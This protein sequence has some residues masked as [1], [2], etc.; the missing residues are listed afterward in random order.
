MAVTV[1]RKLNLVLAP[2]ETKDGLAYIHSVPVGISVFQSCYRGMARAMSSIVTEGMGPITGPSVAAM[3]LQD[4]ADAVGIGDR[5][6]NGLMPE[7]RRLT[8]VGIVGKDSFPY[9]VAIDRK[10][11]DEDKAMEVENLIVYFTLVS[12]IRIPETLSRGMGM[13]GLRDLWGAQITSLELTEFMRS[14]PT[15]MPEGNTGEKPTRPKAAPTS[16]LAA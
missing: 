12:W 1:S 8:N 5:I 3:V 11:I 2:F 14:L 10:L 13:E 6:R 9:G 16:S 4:E 15:L 7:I